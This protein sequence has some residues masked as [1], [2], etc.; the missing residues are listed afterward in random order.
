MRDSDRHVLMVLACLCFSALLSWVVYANMV[1]P[2]FLFP[3][4]NRWMGMVATALG[5]GGF[6]VAA[7][8]SILVSGNFHG[9]GDP[10]VY[11]VAAVPVNTWLYMRLVKWFWNRER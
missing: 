4:L 2:D 6:M 10:A 9:G 7:L 5:I 11:A 3:P 1:L 8:A